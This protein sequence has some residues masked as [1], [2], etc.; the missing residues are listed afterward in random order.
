MEVSRVAYFE[1]KKFGIYLIMTKFRFHRTMTRPFFTRDRISDFDIFEAHSAHALQLAKA[2]L[3]EGHAIDFQ[4]C[5]P[6][7]LLSSTHYSRSNAHTSSWLYRIWSQDSHSTQPLH[8]YSD[9]MS[10]LSQLGYLILLP[11][12][13]Q[14]LANF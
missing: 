10:T 4:V 5:I 7:C 9:I 3:A 13:H 12:G 2:R 14:I 6:R 8:F 11:P 1:R